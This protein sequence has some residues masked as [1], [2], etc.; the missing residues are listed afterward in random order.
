LA[1]AP[2][3]DKEQHS[4]MLVARMERLEISSWH[5][6][7]GM[8]M[9]LAT[10]FDAFGTLTIGYVLPVLAALWKLKPQEI[11]FLI[12]S[13]FVGQIAGGLLFGW[14]AERLGRVRAATYAVAVYAATS[15]ICALSWNFT[16]LLI[17]RTIQ[18]IGLGG[19]VPVGA[20]YINEISRAKGRGRFFLLYELIF[21]TGL[22]GAAVLGFWAV[23][24]YGWQSMFVIGGVAGL[25]AMFVIRRLS[26][27]PRWLM[28]QGRFGEAERVVLEME[29]ASTQSGRILA[30]A[31]PV[32]ALAQP[33]AKTSWTGLFSGIYRKRTFVVW[34]LG[35]FTYFVSYGFNTWLPTIYR[36]YYHLS[37]SNALLYGLL[38]NVVGL[39]GALLCAML[40][41]HLGRRTSYVAAFLLASVPLLLLWRI[42]ARNARE[43]LVLSA[44]SFIFISANSMLFYLYTPEIY[45]T[46]LRSLG[47]G[48]A[49][50]W[51]R[52]SSAI[53]PSIVGFTLAGGGVPGVF[54]LFGV[55]SVLGGMTALGATETTNRALEEISP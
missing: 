28:S 47:T 45:P 12:S 4:A 29:E 46:R 35:I 25:L 30:P 37:V 33:V 27:S 7:A 17:L 48:T 8:A 51:V 20:T 23:P 34:G 32:M 40:V 50:C 49:S 36:T 19:E 3:A 22:T 18:G 9:G 54:L 52:I 53:G 6:R 43:V 39:L 42:G 55:L 15:L 1:A 26:E 31:K 21:P 14:L 13:G 2:L 16:S 24:R 5:V 38:T 11:G 41:D 44:I 10:F